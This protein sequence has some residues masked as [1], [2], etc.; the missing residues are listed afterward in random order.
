M[1]LDAHTLLV[2]GQIILSGGAT[3]I[4]VPLAVYFARYYWDRR[5]WHT[6]RALIRDWARGEFALD[7]LTDEDWRALA[8]TKLSEAGFEPAKMQELLDLAI[9]FARGQASQEAFDKIGLR[10]KE[11]DDGDTDESSSHT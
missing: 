5:R 11:E 8:A 6:F 9:W 10:Q 2:W 7:D 1:A 3:A 4:L